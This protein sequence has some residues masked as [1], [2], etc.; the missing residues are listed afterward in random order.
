MTTVALGGRPSVDRTEVGQA[1]LAC[2]QPAS[3]TRACA[4]QGTS[5][6]VPSCVFL[7]KGGVRRAGDRDG[8]SAPLVFSWPE[9]TAP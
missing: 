8:V 2:H 6:A 5:A 4:L 3:G 7:R 1:G 9:V